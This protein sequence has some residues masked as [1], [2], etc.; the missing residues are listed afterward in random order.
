MKE[1]VK[2]GQRWGEDTRP[3]PKC[4]PPVTQSILSLHSKG[5]LLPFR[6]WGT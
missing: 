5:E 2:G 3:S 4:L 1:V 6:S